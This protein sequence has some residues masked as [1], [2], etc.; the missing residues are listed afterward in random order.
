MKM[1]EEGPLCERT[2]SVTRAVRERMGNWN[3]SGTVSIN[4][5]CYRKCNVKRIKTFKKKTFM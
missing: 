5:H 4:I 2:V 3:V 1:N